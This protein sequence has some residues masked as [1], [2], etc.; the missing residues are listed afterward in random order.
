MPS[1]Q[2]VWSA[3]WR[4]GVALVLS[5]GL[6]FGWWLYSFTKQVNNTIMLRAYALSIYKVRD[7]DGALPD[8]FVGHAD[9]YGRDVVYAHD[10]RHFMLLSYGSDGEPDGPDYLRVL[11]VAFDKTRNNCLVPS[12]DTVVIDG[13]VWQGC[14]K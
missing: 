9:Y 14:G 7:A 1:R 5:F 10:D 8:A 12:R 11:D 3:A 6:Y 4:I 2:R 13:N